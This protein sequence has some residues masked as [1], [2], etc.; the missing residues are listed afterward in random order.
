MKVVRSKRAAALA[1]IAIASLGLAA[2]GGGGSSS[3]GSSGSS[4]SG[5]GG[6]TTTSFTFGGS[7]SGGTSAGQKVGKLRV[8]N[9]FLRDG[10]GYGPVDL[11]DVSNPGP[12]T[13][14]LIKDLGYG[15]VSDYVQP[16]TLTSSGQLWVFP[17]GSTE[18][19]KDGIGGQALSNA[20]WDKGEQATIVMGTS[21]GF[22]DPNVTNISYT[23]ISE[24]DTTQMWK[25]IPGKGA[26]LANVSGAGVEYDAASITLVVD[27]SC[28]MRVDP[29]NSPGGGTGLDNV[30][31]G[32]AVSY[33]VDP[34]SHD[35]SLL[36]TDVSTAPTDC[37]AASAIAPTSVDV[38]SGGRVEVFIFGTSP[39]DLQMVA[40]T[41]DEP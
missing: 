31:N 13:K 12:D 38:P 27:G 39:T 26:I 22:E 8:V 40:A 16:K 17:A 34:G 4:G 24:S 37:T 23:E 14:P 36:T 32:N 5:S 6:K 33:E 25:A 15:E 30:A 19:D 41:V 20:G 18:R 7:D 11:Y 1:A 2:C 29:E 28:P 21:K 35:L 3:D 10:K 9:V